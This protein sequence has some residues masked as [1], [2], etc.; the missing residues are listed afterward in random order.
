MCVCVRERDRD[1]DREKL[2][3]G[4]MQYI[5]VENLDNFIT[6]NRDPFISCQWK[7]N[8]VPNSYLQFSWNIIT[9]ILQVFCTP[10]NCHSEDSKRTV[11]YFCRVDTHG[12]GSIWMQV[13][14][15]R[16]IK[17]VLENWKWRGSAKARRSRV[18]FLHAAELKYPVIGSKSSRLLK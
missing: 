12:S 3:I 18:Q 15:V 10:H 14:F 1:R 13:G 11:V 7:L 17:F 6:R 2:Y 9:Q 4:W 16:C 8:F 5:Y